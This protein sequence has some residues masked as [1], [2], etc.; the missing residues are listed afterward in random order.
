[1]NDDT[2]K[3]DAFGWEGL[4]T[5]E[6]RMVRDMVRAFTT[7]DV[8]PI[9]DEADRNCRFPAELLPTMAELGLFGPTLPEEYG[10]AGANNVM[11]GLMMQE[12]ERADSG[13]RSFMSVQ[14]ALVMYP[15]HRWGSEAQKREH[16]PKLARAD[17]IGC[18]GLTEPDH[19]SDPAGMITRA[20]RT[21]DGYVLNG[22]KMWITNGSIADIAVV[23]AKLDG[24]VRGFIVPKGTPG[25]TA[26]E[27]KGKHSLRASVTSELVLQDCHIPEN[28]LLPEACGLKAPLTCLTQARYGIAWGAT[29]AAMACYETAVR[30][31][32]S[33][34]QF[35]R[36]IA[37]FQLV[38]EKLAYMITEI[39]K[40]QLLNIQLGR[41]KDAG[42]STFVQVS[43]AKR[44]NVDTALNIARMA[45]DI[46]GANGITDEYPVMRHMNNLESVRTYEGTHD[47]HTLIIGR[48]V[49]GFQAFS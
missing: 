30:Y 49:T 9:I 14:S 27:M 17:E 47:I 13:L 28:A 10:C 31:A 39:T 29:G 35:G 7:R 21:T 46:L 23:W 5:E 15:I 45:R 38:Q 8:M 2:V 26:P 43:L 48:E 24:E 16:L 36:P 40:A 18:F 22:A 1:M 3:T 11:Y 33:R 19:G 6:E 32:R 20:D 25:F 41:L 12:L 44:N 4:L 37:S 34:R 42:T